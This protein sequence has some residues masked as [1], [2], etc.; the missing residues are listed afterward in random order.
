MGILFVD[1]LFF[2]SIFAA[3]D[4][5]YAAI[6]SD[7]EIDLV[8][9]E[10]CYFCA[11]SLY[12]FKLLD[13]NETVTFYSQSDAPDAYA[14]REDVAFEHEMYV[15][16]NGEPFGGYD[17]FRQLLRQFGPPIVLSWVMSLPPVKRVGEDIYQYIAANRD[18]YFVCSWEG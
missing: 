8:Y 18:R 16:V 13:I 5:G 17:A 10:R 4:R 15:F 1:M 14:G 6:V 3:Y 9:D 2:L 11:R 12:L 7:R